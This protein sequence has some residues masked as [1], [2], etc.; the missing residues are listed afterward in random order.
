MRVLHTWAVAILG[1]AISLAAGRAASAVAVK[2]VD[3]V[4]S[5]LSSET[6]QDSEPFLAVDP[7]DLSRMVISAF[8]DDPAGDKSTAAPVF[9]TLDG[10]STWRIAKPIPIPHQTAD[11]TH[12]FVGGS[13]LAAGAL[14]PSG[15][16]GLGV[17]LVKLKANDAA[18]VKLMHEL[19]TRANVDQP[20][21]TIGKNHAGADVLYIGENDLSDSSSAATASVEISED[22]GARFDQ[23]RLDLRTVGGQ[24]G[25]SIRVAIAEDGT[26]YAAYFGW[27]KFKPVDQDEGWVTS[28]VVVARDDQKPGHQHFSDLIDK[29]LHAGKRVAPGVLVHWSNKPT[30]GPERTGSTLSLAVDP[31]KSSWIYV[32][33]AD[34]V[35]PQKIYTLHVARS[36]DSGMTWKRIMAVGNATCVALAVARNGTL[37]M[38]YHE[39]VGTGANARWETHLRQTANDFGPSSIDSLLANTRADLSQPGLPYLGDYNY[40]L[41]VGTEFRGVFSANNF[42]DANSFPMGVTYLREA[43]L[44]KHTLGDGHGG[45]VAP[46]IDPFYFSA[47]V[48]GTS[49]P[50]GVHLAAAHGVTAAGPAGSSSSVPPAVRDEASDATAAAAAPAA[51]LKAQLGAADVVMV[52][53]VIAT[54]A[55][56]PVFIATSEGGLASVPSTRKRISEHDPH[57]KEAV[58][59][60]QRPLKGVSAD[61]NVV[62][63]YPD[64][65]DLMWQ[66]SYPRLK[67]GQEGLFMLRRSQ[68]AGGQL[69]SLANGKPLFAAPTK[70]DLL[71]KA[72]VE[73]VIELLKQ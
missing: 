63:L 62:V 39:L 53:R 40:L 48:F 10:G 46:S 37:G 30:L 51:S 41:A 13:L 32:A 17:D 70:Q 72:R 35:G 38:L 27:R 49:K 1:F 29:D 52:G 67:E 25:P 31:L 71:D 9:L 55:A 34:N 73:E 33:W 15:S 7:S 42:P 43:D 12:A 28:D 65:L 6:N 14:K 56:S 2:I 44:A 36:H 50:G 47:E 64:T 5:D 58:I 16:G 22:S 45:A 23:F 59:Q 66:R 21:V 68:H 18:L 57:W 8:I 24:D 4:P 19:G 69:Q 11:I 54:R 3:A 26:A 60:V 20:F 61:E